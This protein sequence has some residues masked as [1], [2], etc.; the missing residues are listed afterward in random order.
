MDH[1]YIDSSKI[2]DCIFGK[3]NFGR[4]SK[5]KLKL[6]SANDWESDDTIEKTKMTDKAANENKSG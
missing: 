5:S 2:A 3:I 4:L 1:F 6:K